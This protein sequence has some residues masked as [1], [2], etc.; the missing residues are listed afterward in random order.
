ML[1]VNNFDRAEE[2]LILLGAQKKSYQ[3]NK[4]E[5][6]TIGGVE[7]TIDE[8]PFLEPFVEIEGKSEDVV[9]KASEILGFDYQQAFFCSVTTLYHKKYGLSDAAI[10]NGIP[11]I[12]F[13]MENPFLSA[14]QKA[15][16]RF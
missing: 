7:V 3:E 2:L 9:K 6:W 16:P 4:R 8:W 15:H 11:K 1:E 13:D 12:T 10:N 5:L 14:L